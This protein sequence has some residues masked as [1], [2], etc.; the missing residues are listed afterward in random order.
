M[1][2][3]TLQLQSWFASPI[4]LTQHPNPINLNAALEALF[5][6]RETDEF[7]N[8]L[9]SHI[10]QSELFESA[11]NLFKW[12]EQCV[13]DLRSFML[14]YVGAAVAQLNGYS[15]EQMAQLTLQ[16]HTWFHVTRHGGSFIAHNH[17]NASWSAV[18][19]V[20]AGEAVAGRPDSG[21][22]RFLD[23][24]PGS[25]AY[26]DAGNAKLRREFGFGHQV[27]RLV[28]GQLVIFP[29]YLV[30]EVATFLGRDTRISVATNCWF[31]ARS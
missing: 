19:C 15:P 25:N 27:L 5:L 12:K 30:H 23:H 10:P 2:P 22:L 8:K 26:L 4:L 3:P 24:R 11:F 18:Y 17:P 14:E 16:N 13:V 21:A 7:R 28:A 29:S 1:P 6:A 20:R 31:T 9:P